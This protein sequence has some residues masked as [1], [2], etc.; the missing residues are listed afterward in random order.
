MKTR[1]VEIKN[2]AIIEGKTYA[3]NALTGTKVTVA[4]G[5]INSSEGTAIISTGEVEVS[6]G[7]IFTEGLNAIYSTGTVTVSGGTIKKSTETEGAVLDYRGTGVVNL[8]GGNIT[9]EEYTLSSTIYNS[10]AGTISVSGAVVTNKGAEYAIYNNASGT[11]E[12]T[13]GSV[14]TGFSAGIYNKAR[15]TCKSTRRNSKR[16]CKW[17]SKC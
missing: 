15:R 7:T 6:G 13:A 5:T 16:L 4:G 11:I 8:K 2:D 1:G 17:Y 14:S 3:I 12:I 9:S 10:S